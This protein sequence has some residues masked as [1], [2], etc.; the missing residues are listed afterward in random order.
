MKISI[1]FLWWFILSGTTYASIILDHN[2]IWK[3]HDKGIN[4]G[5]QWKANLFNDAN[6][7]TGKGEF[8]FGDN[9]VTQLKQ[10]KPCYYFRKTFNV[11]NPQQFASFVVNLRRDDGVIVYLNG[12]KLFSNNLPTGG[13][14]FLTLALNDC[15]DDGDSIFTF[16][17]PSSAFLHGNNVF[18]VEIHPSSVNDVDLTFEMNLEAVLPLVLPSI[19]RGPY[20]QTTTT[21]SCSI[22][23][24]T[25][26]ETD[27]K[28]SYG[29]NTSYGNAIMNTAMVKDHSI[30]IEGL[31]PNTKYFYRIGSTAVILEHGVENYFYTAPDFGSTQP[32][33]IWALGDFGNGSSQQTQVLQ[34]YLN[35]LGGKRNDM[36]IWLGDNAYYNGT[37]QEYG[38]FVFDVYKNQFKNWNFYP[39]LGNHDYGQAGYLSTASLGT[40]FPYFNIFNLPKEAQCGGVP[41]STE[42]YYSYNWGNVHFIALD[43]Y[44]ALN[45]SG[46]QMYQWL[47][48]DLQL[49]TTKW[50]IA[51]W[52]HP[53]FSKGTHNSDTEIEM[54]DMRENIVPLLERF[55]VDLVL[56][57]HS[58]TYE[59]SYFIHGHYG[60]E[61]SFDSAHIVQSGDGLS[62]PYLKDKEHNG[63]IYSV[64]GVGGQVSVGVS[65]GFPHN[66]MVSSV[67]SMAGSTSIE[68]NGDTMNCK[69]ILFNGSIADEFYIVKNGNP[70]Y[71]WSGSDYIRNPIAF[72][73]PSKG[74]IK[75]FPGYPIKKK[76]E[77]YN[78]L[79]ILLFEDELF[80]IKTI[81]FQFLGTGVFQFVWSDEYDRY[82]QTVVFD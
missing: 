40:N 60:L 41:S 27:S 48:N 26:V 39:A 5:T 65:S 30:K 33:Q 79:G 78:H 4:F 31:L 66:A 77:V 46:S 57:G 80:D 51:Y 3:Y 1:L 14:N 53:P 64:C 34:S 23:W 12:T 25:D 11:I 42:K 24:R 19:S 7:S 35:Y 10:N 75:V 54:I 59:R 17:L 68:V 67:S 73:N 38:N 62:I 45:H 29:L 13:V 63:T 20:L 56:T 6:W 18:A 36:W 15:I 44:G 2:S 69:F 43:S 22:H 81:D 74:I 21:N 61:D 82:S 16:N 50:I 70:R 72:P 37:D 55:G 9:P 8:G 32:L 49:N 76:L 47:L 71:E 28:V 58:H 52:H